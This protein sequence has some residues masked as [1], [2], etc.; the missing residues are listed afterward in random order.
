[1]LLSNVLQQH[2]VRQPDRLITV[3]QGRETSYA[4]MQENCRR[5]GGYFHRQGLVQGDVVALLLNNSD[6]FVTCYFACQFAGLVVLPIN[7]RLAPREIEYILNHSEARMLVYDHDLSGI[8]EQ[9]IP[10][11]PHLQHFVHVGEGGGGFELNEAIKLGGEIPKLQQQEDDT[12]VIFYT[13]GTT[14]KPKGVMLTH[15]NCVAVASMWNEALGM[16]KEDRVMIVA[17]LFH[18][19]A[20]HVFM[21][22]L[23]YGGGT[24]VIESGFHPQGTIESL[25]KNEVSIFFGV[26]AMYM[27]LLNTPGI[28]SMEV[29]NLRKFMYGAA[30]MPYELIRRIKQLFPQTGVQNLYGQTENSPGT[31]TLGD[32]HA[33]SKAGSVGKPLPRSEVRVV[34]EE[35]NEMPIGQV[36]EIAIKGDHVMKGYLKNPEATALAIRGGWLFSG[37]L[38]KLDE[39]GF[40]YIVDRKKDMLI[41]GGENIYPIEVEEVL[42]EMPEVLEAA[43]V[44]VPHEVYGEIPKA[45]VVVK[46]GYSLTEEQVVSF[47]QERLAKYKVPTLVEFVSELPR[48]ASG[49]VLKTV[50]RG[51]IKFS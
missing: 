31:T 39:E 24:L 13:S 20:A 34:D 25:Q 36:G 26:P 47:C 33:L 38:G 35:G 16:Q 7:T 46:D 41:R 30:P 15:R 44:G 5:L 37:D 21:L 45:C 43:V 8:V 48:N 2:A 11:V 12:A 22:P 27:I 4:H 19:A 6:S 18:C 17:P 14:G 29:P 42:Y 40:L 23:I 1:M 50:L 3:F 28:E 51:E 9:V 32:E 49:K 10:Q